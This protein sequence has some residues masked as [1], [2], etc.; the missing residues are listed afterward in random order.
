MPDIFKSSSA[1]LLVKRD[2]HKSFVTKPYESV[3]TNLLFLLDDFER[4][5]AVF[6]FRK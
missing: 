3:N 5:G 1:R 2:R 4:S 6:L